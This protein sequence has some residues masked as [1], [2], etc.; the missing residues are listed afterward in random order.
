VQSRSPLRPWQLPQE[1]PAFSG[2][3]Q[4]GGSDT[5][6]SVVGVGDYFGNN[7]SDIL[8]RNSAGDTWVEAITNGAFAGWDQIGGSNTSYSVPVTVGPPALT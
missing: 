2:W 8:F 6:Y 5:T 1:P 7:T 3:H 4:I